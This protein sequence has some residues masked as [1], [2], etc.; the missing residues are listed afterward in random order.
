[1]ERVVIDLLLPFDE[2]TNEMVLMIDL[3]SRILRDCPIE[4]SPEQ[5]RFLTALHSL[6][7]PI[8]SNKETVK[9]FSLKYLFTPREI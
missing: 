5:A 1:M 8:I 7:P 2:P 3:S 9:T 4:N 6:F